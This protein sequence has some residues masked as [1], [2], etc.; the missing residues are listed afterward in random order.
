VLAY[1]VGRY[2]PK[3]IP[4]GLWARLKRSARFTNFLTPEEFTKFIALMHGLPSSLVVLIKPC[5][6]A[7]RRRYSSKAACSTA[8]S[9]L[10]RDP[11]LSRTRSNPALQPGLRPKVHFYLP[12]REKWGDP[13]WRANRPSIV[14]SG[15]RNHVNFQLSLRIKA[16][17]SM[18][19]TPRA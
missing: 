12:A 9:A 5:N 19:R 6:E 2:S 1:A 4:P 18:H 8:G 7:I 10:E 3:R 11:S 17:S 16:R 15:Q 14:G 13:S